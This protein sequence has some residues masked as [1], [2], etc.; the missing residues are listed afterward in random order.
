MLET[1]RRICETAH[2]RYV[3]L[4]I[5]AG[6]LFDRAIPTAAVRMQARG[7]LADAGVPVLLIPGNHDPLEPGSP[8]LIDQWPGNVRVAREPGWQSFTIGGREVWAFGYTTADAHLGAWERFPGCAPDAII[9]LHATCLMPGIGDDRYYRFRP[10]EIPNCAYLALGHHHMSALVSPMPRACYSG[11][12]EPLEPQEAES[13]A[14]LVEIDGDDV[15]HMLLPMAMRRHREVTIDVTGR[16]TDEV[17][18]LAL[19]SVSHDDLLTVR[20][21]GLLNPDDPLDAGVLEAELEKDVFFA[22]VDDRGLLIPMEVDDTGGVMGALMTIARRE[23]AA[24]PED[25]PQTVVLQR[26]ARYAQLALEG[27]L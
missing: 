19:A 18:K 15:M 5:I 17:Y 23:I 7:A 14:L 6:D 21:T 1:L 9:A 25:D 4:L 8:Y 2:E 24:V 3:D 12:P 26:A 27:K 10:G 22:R 13:G 16:R 11:S 20:L